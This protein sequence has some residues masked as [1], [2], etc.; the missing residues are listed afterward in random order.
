MIARRTRTPR[1]GTAPATGAPILHQAD[2]SAGHSRRDGVYLALVH[3]I[4]S[5][6][7]AP[8][9]RLPSEDAIA[10]ELRA[11]RATVRDALSR[12]EASGLI[13]R[14]H[15][16]GTYVSPTA[17]IVSSRIDRVSTLS[18]VISENGMRP[19]IVGWRVER[20]VPPADVAF[21]LGLGPDDRTWAVSRTYLA[22]G[23]PAAWCLAYVPVTLGGRSV[24]RPATPGEL[25]WQLERE[26]D[27]LVTHVVASIE[28]VAA[29]G[30]CTGALGVA[31][32]TP[33]L[34][35]RNLNLLADGRPILVGL[36]YS[37]SRVLATRL[38]QS[39]SMG[40]ALAPRP[41]TRVGLRAPDTGLAATIIGEE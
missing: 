6:T 30:V 19:G 34:L 1:Q 25:R 16:S 27:V 32:G 9:A 39:L 36:N 4:H 21:D 22:D 11:S 2:R 24:R 40:P 7:H 33:L 37:D 18:E 17:A 12:L 8:G 26:L 13:V 29:D 35:N 31:G 5:G 15:G 20:V 3:S 23:T 38:V 10:R 14:R 41:G 28:A